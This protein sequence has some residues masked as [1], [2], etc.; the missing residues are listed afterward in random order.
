VVVAP[1]RGRLVDNASRW[2]KGVIN[3]DEGSIKPLQ[4]WG[5]ADLVLDLTPGMDRVE[6][7][8][9][10]PWLEAVL[11]KTHCTEF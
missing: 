1:T 8:E 4:V 3:D 7:I 9:E 11:G 5:Y 10:T 6:L 2:A